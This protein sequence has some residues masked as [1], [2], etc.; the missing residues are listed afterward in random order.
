MREVREG[1]RKRNKKIILF[2]KTNNRLNKILVIEVR[3]AVSI[4]LFIYLFIFLMSFKLVVS[5][6][7]E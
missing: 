4:D 2:I 1:R 3:R 7:F 6:I 5:L